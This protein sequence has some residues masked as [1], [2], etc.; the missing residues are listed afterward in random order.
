MQTLSQGCVTRFER[1]VRVS[2]GEKKQA[3]IVVGLNIYSMIGRGDRIRW[4]R[5]RKSKV[6]AGRRVKGRV[7]Y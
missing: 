6:C 5:A 7:K 4:P 1:L 2:N 3:G